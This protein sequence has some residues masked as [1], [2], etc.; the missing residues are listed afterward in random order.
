MV[1][2]GYETC[3]SNTA[4]QFLNCVGREG[5]G[6]GFGLGLGGEVVITDYA[7]GFERSIWW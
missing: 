7:K 6:Y 5:E 1:E 3:T 2:D 4:D